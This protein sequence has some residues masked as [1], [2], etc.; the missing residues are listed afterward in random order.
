LPDA[1][2][3]IIVVVKRPLSNFT[4]AAFPPQALAANVNYEVTNLDSG[5]SR[6]LTGRDLGVNGLVVRLTEKP[7]SALFRYRR[8]S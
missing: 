5:E 8:K 1:G 6:N 4:Q 3:G 2:E 7:D